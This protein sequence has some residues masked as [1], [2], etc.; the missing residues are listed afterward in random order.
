MRLRAH[1]WGRSLVH[2]GGAGSGICGCIDEPAKKKQTSASGSR[3]TSGTDGGWGWGGGASSIFMSFDQSVPI[4]LW[5]SSCRHEVLGAI[6]G[7]LNLSFS[8]A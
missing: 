4:G 2:V 6:P 1:D 5:D 7:Q 8:R 3:E